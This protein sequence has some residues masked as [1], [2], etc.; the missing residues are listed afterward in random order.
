MPSSSDVEVLREAV[1]VAHKCRATYV[2]TE[3]VVERFGGQN[4]WV[5]SVSVF[6]IDLPDVDTCYAWESPNPDTGGKRLYMVLRK[7]PVDTPLDAVRASI[8]ADHKKGV[9]GQ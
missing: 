5:G 9:T 8:V 4:V 7:P 6:K 2:R 1:E 3:Q